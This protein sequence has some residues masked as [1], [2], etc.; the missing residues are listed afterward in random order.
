MAKAHDPAT[1]IAVV[2]LSCRFPGAA[3]PEAFWRL[4]R[5]GEHAIRDVPADRWDADRLR[6]LDPTVQCPRQGGFLDH[7]DRFD[8][9]FF[10]IPPREAN[11]MDPQQRLVLELAW[12]ALEDAGIVPERL[13]GTRTGV[14]VG[15]MLDDYAALSHRAG[16]AS[17]GAH[18]STGLSRGVIANR[19]SYALGLRGRSLVV[20]TGQSSAL[21]AVH[22][23]C[24]SLRRGDSALALAGGVNL[25]LAPESTIGVAKFGA[26]SPDSR[27]YVFD[28]R[29]NG[30][31]R[32]EGGGLVVLKR[33]ADAE[34]DGDD[35][36]CVVLGGA[37]NNDGGGRSLTAPDRDAQEDVIRLA[38]RDAGVTPAEVGY[39][40]LHGTGTRLG[41]PVEA[42]ALGAAIGAERAEP[43]VVGSAKTNV[44]HL[45]GAAGVVGLIKAAL[46]VRRREIPPSLNFAEP[47]PDIPLDR[48]GLRVQTGLSGW[49]R[50]AE[51]LV[52]G[53]SSFGMGGTNCH[54]V[55]AEP[56][57]KAAGARA[58][59]PNAVPWVLSGRTGAALREQAARLRESIAS[60]PELEPVDVG[61]SLATS[62]TAFEHRAAVVGG[63]R[64]SLLRGLDA[65]ADGEAGAGTVRGRAKEGRLAFLFTG[66]GSQ[67]LG[68]GR[69]LHAAFPVFAA[70]FDE[71]CAHLDPAL[72]DVLHGDPE[73]L[74]RTEFTQPALFAVE[75]A[76]HRLLDSFGLRPDY[77]VGHSIGELTAAHVAGIL[78]LPDACRLV[79]ARAAL[80]QAAP[81]GGAMLAVRATEA[82]VL[83][84]LDDRVALAA[85]NGPDS[86]VLSGDADALAELADRL[87]ERGARVKRL[88]VGH[89]FHSHHMDDVLAEF[90]RVAATVT[91]HEPTTPVVSNVTGRLTD[92]R[93]PAYWARHVRATVRFHDGIRTLLDQG[94]TTFLELGPDPVLTGLVEGPAVTTAALLRAGRGEEDTLVTALATAHS[95]GVDVDWDAFFAP[96]GP[97][98]VP[99][100]TYAF[101]RRRFWL[102][103]TAAEAH[104]E[105]PE[106]SGLAQR[107]R[108]LTDDDRTALVVDVIARHSAEVLEHDSDEI[109]PTSSF[110]ALG[111][112][113][114]TSV[115]L[116]ARLA[117]ETG[118]ALPGSLVYDHPTPVALAKRLVAEL[119]GDRDRHQEVPHVA[120]HGEPVAI[121]AMSCRYPGGVTSPDDL[122]RLVASGAD[123]ISELPT[124]R[125]W[126]VDGLYD[127]SPDV[128]G[129]TYSRHGGFLGGVDAFDAEFF[130]ISPREALAMDP[131]QRLLLETAWEAFERAGIRADSLPGS[132][133]GVF[134]GTTAPD[135]GPRLHERA[136]GSEGYL[137]T[138]TT[139]SVA[140]G[141]IAYTFGLE[142]PA[143]SVD[144]ACSSSLVA[145]HLAVQSLRNGEC[146]LAL[147]GGATVMSTPGMFI[148]FSRQR[149][150]SPDGRCKAF[151]DSAD[152][153]GWAEGVGVLLLERLSDAQRNGHRVLA[154]IRG[155]AI[156]QDGASN[157]LTAP[158]GP[159]QERV[160]RQAL[161]SAGL[162]ARDVDAVEAHGT[163]TRLGDP[164]EAQALLA[165][166]GQ[167]RETPLWLG[168]LKSNIGHAQA[169][170]GIGGV[171]KMVMAMRHGVLPRTLHVD[172][173]STRVDWSTGAVE[174]L[175]RAQPWASPLR[176]AAV[177][178]F[179]ISGTNAHVILEEPPA[180]EV[181]ERTDSAGTAPWVLS[182]KTPRALR[183]QA[184]RLVAHLDANPGLHPADI[185]LSTL[186][187]TA[188][189]HRA[190]VLGRRGLDALARDES[191]P[192]VVRGTATKGKTVFV[193]PGQGSQ[194][195]G[196][197][198]GL[199]DTSTVFR[200][201]LT[202]CAKALAPYVDWDLL[203]VLLNDGDLEPVDV[204]QPALWAVMVSLAEVWRSHGVVPDAVMGHSQGEIAAACVAGAL[205]LDDGARVAALRS[206]AITTLAGAGGMASVAL[207]AD[208]VRALVRDREIAI[209]AVN[210]PASTVVSGATAALEEFLDNLHDVRTRR[211]A[212]DYASHSAQ[213]EQLRE[214]LL[215]SLAEV[216]P[217]DS[218]I[219]FYSTVT[220][221]RL[222]TTELDADYWYR[223]LRQPV[224]LEKT[225]R[226][227]LAGG[228]RTFVESSPHPVLAVGLGETFEAAG[229]PAVVVP[230]LRRDE[231]GPDRLLLSLARAHANGV[232]VAWESLLP[233]AERVELP[234]YAFQRERFWL[235]PVTST[236]DVSAAGLTGVD[237]PLLGAAV[238][239]AGSGTTVLTGRVSLA[240]LPWLRDHAVGG[241]VLLP[242]T[243]F[244]DLVLRAGAEVG[245][246]ELAELTLEEPLLLGDGEVPLQVVLEAPDDSGRRAVA[247]HSRRD[248]D[249][250]RHAS[251]AVAPASAGAPVAS[252]P[253]PPVDAEPVDV[254]E[255][256]DALAERGYDYGPVFQGVVGAWR[257]GDRVHAEVSLPAD[258]AATGFGIHPALLDAA[259]HAGLL[260]AD[261]TRLPFTWS[262]VRLHRTDATRLRVR[263][264]HTGADAFTFEA[265]DTE[266]QPV[267]SVGSLALRR[268]AA[269]A[270]TADPLYAVE[271]VGTAPVDGS[272]LSCAVVT[273]LDAL[274]DV[275]DV[276]VL[277]VSSAGQHDVPT[278]VRA[279][280]HHVLAQ[281]RKWLRGEE[282]ASSR[283]VVATTGAV[284]VRPDDDVPDLAAA[285]VWGLVKSVQ[286]EEPDRFVLLDVD[287]PDAVE[288]AARHAVSGDEPQLALRDGALFVPRLNRISG[289]ESTWD[290]DGPVLI[291]GASGSLGALI[292]RHL[293]AEHGVRNLVLL[294]RSR[295][296]EL[297]TELA[298][299]GATAHFAAC[300]VADRD[301]LAHVID[302]HQPTAVIHTAGILDDTTTTT[303]T[304]DRLDTVLRPK[305]DG[306]WNLHELTRH[307]DLDAFILF[308]SVTATLGNAGQGNYT[309]A[310]GFLDGLAQHRRAHGLPASS[311]AWGLWAESTGMTGHLGRADLARMSRGGIAPLTSEEGI[312]LFD[313]ARAVDRATVVPAKLDLASL[314]GHGAVVPAVL[315]GL[316]RKPARAARDDTSWAR[317]VAALPADERRAAITDLVRVTA[318]TVLGHA[319]A[320]EVDVTRSFKDSGFDSLMSVE[321]RNQLGAATGVL[322]PATLVFDHPTPRAVADFIEERVLG[323]RTA[324]APARASTP[325]DEPIAIVAMS[326]RYPGS[327]TSPDDLWRLVASGADVVGGFPGNRGWDLAGL[328]DP[329]P[330][331]TGTTYCRGGGFLHDADTFDAEFF[332]ISPREA[333]AMDPQQRLL[334]ETTWEAFERAGM[335]PESLRGSDTGA[336]VG[337]MYNDYASR[338]SPAPEGFEGYIANGSF[339]SVASGRIAYTF[340]LEGP[341]V[342]VDTAC[343]SSLVAL[344]LAAQSLRRGEC[345]L[346]LAG[347]VAVMSTPNTFIEFS[348]QRALSP[349]GRCKAFSDS[350][351]GT[352]WAE[353]VGILLLE[354]LSDAQRNGHQ[355]LAVVRGS[356]INQDGA[357]NGL[358]APN[359][360]AQERVIRQALNSAGLTARDVDAVE[361]HG[362]GTRLG[363]P[364]EAQALLATYGQ[365]RETPLWLGSLKSNIG[366]AQAAAGVGG[367]IKMVMA[368]RHGVLPRT[369]H[370]DRPTSHVDWTTGAVELLTRERPWTAQP[371]RAGVSSF[372]ISGTNAH[373][374]LEGPPA[375]DPAE[376][377]DGTAVVPLVLSAKTPRALRDQAARL[378]AH[379]DANPGLR[380]ADLALSAGRRTTFDHRAAVVGA[381]LDELS[382]GLTAVAGD[383]LV[384]EAVRG[385]A[386][387][388]LLAFMFTG[389]GGQRPGMGRRLHERHP[390]FAAAFDEVCA[391]F[392]LPLREVVFGED[393]RLDQTRYAQAALFAVETALY[394]LVRAHGV[395]PDRLIGH[396]IGELTAAHAAGVLS[397]AD[398][399]ALVEA[400]GRL[401]Q[402]APAGGAMVAVRADEDAVAA[403]L[404]GLTGLLDVAAV[405]GPD[406]VVVSGDADAAAELEARMAAKGVRTRRLRVSHAFHSPHMDGVLAE[407][408]RI[409]STVRFHEPEIPVVSNVTGRIAEA[410]E[411]C[412]PAYWAGHIRAAV[413]FHDGVRALRD[414]GVT[415]FLELGPDAVLTGVVGNAFEDLAAA[416]VL[417]AGRDEER[418]FTAALAFAHVRG[419]DV[420]WPEA[421]GARPV[422]LPTY[423]FQRRRHWLDA[424]AGSGDAAGGQD[425][426]DHPLL[427][428][429][430]DLADGGG[431]L[432]TGSLSPAEQPWLADH[433]IAGL[434][435]L[436]GSA[437][438]DLAVRAGDAVGCDRVDELTLHEP[439]VLA[440]RGALRLQL[441][442]RRLD[443]DRYSFTAHTAPDGGSGGW[444]EHA[445]GVLTAGA[446]PA[447]AALPWPPVGARPIDVEEH[448]T[449]VENAGIDCGPAF[450]GLVAAWQ[451]GEDTCAEVRLPGG[452]TAGYGLHPAVLDAALRPLAVDGA[453]A[454]R[455]PFDW[456]G[457]ALH[458]AGAGAV[459]VRITPT[460]A[461]N[462]VR[463]QLDDESGAVVATVDA[464]SL[465]P[466]PVERLAGR[467]AD[468]DL[469]AVDWTP[470]DTTAAASGGT[471]VTVDG[472]SGL[473]E[474]AAAVR[475]GAAAPDFVLVEA[476]ND[477][478]GWRHPTTAV[479]DAVTEALA[480]AQDWLAEPVFLTA[481]LVVL[482]RGGVAVSPGEAPEPGAAAVWGLLRSAQAEHADRIV[483]VDV[484][485]GLPAA[486]SITAALARGEH[487][488]AVRGD[489]VHVPR[490]ATHTA[491]PGT[492]LTGT[493]L[494]TGATGQL[495][496]LVARH[497]A[498]AHGVRRMLLLSRRGPAAPDADRL[499]ADLTGAGVDVR[500]R[501]C[502]IADR[503]ALA[504]V[505]A[506]EPDLNAVVHLAGVLDDGVLTSLTPE[507]L[508]AVLR[509]KVDAAWHLHE[510]TRDLDAFVLF[511]SIAGT[512]G[513]PG[514]ANY[515]AANAFLDALAAH[516]HAAGLPGRSLAWGLWDGDGMAGG[517]RAEDR[518]RLARSG[519]APMATSAALA[520]LD[521]ALGAT[522]PVVLPARLSGMAS[523]RLPG[524]GRPGRRAVVAAEGAGTP[525]PDRI[526][527]LS[528]ERRDEELLEVVRT[529]IAA[530]LGHGGDVV[531]DP[532]Q[533]FRELGFDS[534]MAVELRNRLNAETGLRLPNTLVFDHPNS[535]ALATHLVG[536]LIPDAQPASP[537]AEIDR[538]DALLA[539]TDPARHREITSRLEDLLWKWKGGGPADTADVTADDELSDDA[540]FA[541][542][543]D[544]LG[545]R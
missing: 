113:S 149:G 305:V 361:A 118:I 189:D 339:G 419:V 388:G 410:G 273:D 25:V 35:I 372:G 132:R 148:E 286:A 338:L 61:F 332:G 5:R 206:Q 268:V 95:A 180:V 174:L 171:I 289:G 210:G 423:A 103:A 250:T 244:V 322:L 138:G 161:N 292:A 74:D 385:S 59:T 14:F 485:G 140:S 334:L 128:P 260:P 277:D 7:V 129:K 408:E 78:T 394:R 317:R 460:G 111:H 159:S 397:L 432:W 313:A 69:E 8:A 540:L 211:I 126:D 296:P 355:V 381:D 233:A 316:V 212:V 156:N 324:T 253:W 347:G 312:R 239:V 336:F 175:T 404:A 34:A 492:R 366:H 248:Q 543:D 160:I 407:F 219:A 195:I 350:A 9:A 344:H 119:L 73:R 466:L 231:G 43:L 70:A 104:E 89:A 418:T 484:A 220:G 487:Q 183:D 254:D 354:R 92:L 436:P 39:V 513:T 326:C 445:T 222:D 301:A 507:R 452:D 87:R 518:A 64:T 177:S 490:L 478:E 514:Q 359:G 255:L 353:G 463:L 169:A 489:R 47:H 534:L 457:V 12:E 80:M 448:R 530:V 522:T 503:D 243:A 216:S 218:G 368:M 110:K 459:R 266:G 279:T 99:L 342:S 4:L 319:A 162:T 242:G 483:L 172:Q 259:L 67:R 236:G 519:I 3:D 425:R 349:D 400:R 451:D 290:A 295:N 121:V 125:G 500:L 270:L 315:R 455:V 94:V 528:P 501:A 184:A 246:A 199:W 333:S 208:E 529:G 10:G 84:H 515:A 18:T 52:A 422:A 337:V 181:A 42:A 535:A 375:A 352:G 433:V 75:T 194:W 505:L 309:A 185:A 298:D 20:D 401:M 304:P 358:T 137:L 28:A 411:L 197:A 58:A 147:A 271:W 311:L 229:V 214:K 321:L 393:D 215:E 22:Q 151:S 263:L 264:T 11:A 40:E 343:S 481:R 545:A 450:Q 133:T 178:S 458:A 168:S 165:T 15:A 438:V 205:S 33:L 251:G 516:R 27:A 228:F 297:E 310:N 23:A 482:T 232:A 435:V 200:D 517:L 6:D 429:V 526:A 416:A 371:R 330:G 444:T 346:A 399:C 441:A 249:W 328:Y 272:R 495:G 532:R 130:G 170:A 284:A 360:P 102:D 508:D 262:G 32:G 30:Y 288:Q 314:R 182:A 51:R 396:S 461:E 96:G 499:V 139:P 413:R 31:V 406:A 462:T 395:V 307:L 186:N 256:Y 91:Y 356:A 362:T 48:L 188:F 382:R 203:D 389:Q 207:P 294:S 421:P 367:V 533:S 443:A 134:V 377:V 29:A 53:V 498:T 512:A 468:G 97:N 36:T 198:R 340:G 154:V 426:A 447:P 320:T 26:L 509:P 124:D 424:P 190:V 392:D 542:L 223:N 488:L 240:D 351:D 464:L 378:A 136:D 258:Q 386:D 45:E 473:A 420:E 85:V 141:R 300:D 442:V 155:S 405:N 225:T 123:V 68:M 412:S 19:V 13:R 55:L 506:T 525:L 454:V 398:A 282:F 24:E 173:P 403:E 287:R 50:P 493:V 90:E 153:T 1:T 82:D 345:S 115:E 431:K 456:K 524:S 146:S 38:H 176:R 521:A 49:P 471:W 479:R 135:Y 108:P 226:A 373:V 285:S 449:R 363:D 142:G 267:V 167:D 83:P 202:E 66:Q 163:G 278:A 56:P 166:Y 63:D 477:T 247:V 364:I 106:P 476:T 57:A 523:G 71:V 93:A 201:R 117:T 427:G 469:F 318:V 293:V 536:L 486:G 192:L 370:A 81:T 306:A 65:I 415:T 112:T 439:V 491:G 539:T 109:D 453:G 329:D 224:E 213:V 158:N 299:L 101:Q 365:D 341:A 157:G 241:V 281:V 470:L 541:A 46:S 384:P 446:R 327:V 480:L 430:I 44:G 291:T 465:R 187:R 209:A 193:F 252:G 143:V 107:L 164:I 302:Q 511:S 145:L 409:A 2:G 544:E 230:S 434:V 120:A 122:W 379:L 204:V 191:D 237:H 100:P 510:L 440:E 504:R 98:R 234:T 474:L 467:R 376:P 245:C 497:L 348:R 21:V 276:V 437:L 325:T 60:R 257:S 217:R 17:V 374:V 414:E 380:P 274:A 105:A 323:E 221:D 86:V 152:G 283:L 496:G 527:T 417:R 77:L 114:I 179:G 428:A 131:Q 531:V 127:P 227:L 308:S 402:A 502:D 261:A 16:P 357:S 72:R 196:M 383:R 303:L 235:T 76:L 369:L 238:A 116:A 144:T 54:V 387:G 269:G 390:V 537:L 41:D 494:V 331:R 335:A 475:A 472:R 62:R 391:H 538:L 520:L 88:R 37:V 275:P 79:T 265:T 280:A 150:L